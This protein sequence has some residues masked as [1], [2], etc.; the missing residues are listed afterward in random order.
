MIEVSLKTNFKTALEKALLFSA[1]PKIVREAAAVA[2]SR[3]AASVA[4]ALRKEM[5]DI[6]D[7]PAPLTAKAILY[8][9]ADAAGL[10]ASVFIRDDASKGT[11]PSKYLAAEILGGAR[12]DKR[13]ERALK[14]AGIMQ[15][16]QSLVPG[17]GVPLDKYGNIPGALMVLILS[18][19]GA[20]HEM[21]FNANASAAT[22]RKLAKGLAAIHSSGTDFFVAH[23]KRGGEPLG[24]WRIVSSGK[25][26]PFLLFA[27]KRPEYAE[28]FPFDAEVAHFAAVAW[29]REMR[30]ALHEQIER[31]AGGK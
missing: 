12:R 28:R 8:R 23:S 16:G 22:K 26:Q 20:F 13:S 7:R 14:G 17:R 29:P 6:F 15:G 2:L 25:V 10:R 30:R 1:G 4:F 18:R 19:L 5:P 21:G 9:K 31:Y 24:I 27:N 11:P 3:T